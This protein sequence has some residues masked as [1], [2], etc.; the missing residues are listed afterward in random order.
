MKLGLKRK[1]MLN[2]FIG[3]L[4]V[5]LLAIVGY[6]AQD[7]ISIGFKQIER[8]KNEEIARKKIIERYIIFIT[9]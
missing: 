1:G 9:G 3:F 2:I 6:I 5:G 8:E 7:R 4:L